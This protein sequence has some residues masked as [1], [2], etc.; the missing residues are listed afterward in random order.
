MRSLAPIFGCCT[1]GVTGQDLRLGH[2]P[3]IV[4]F[5]TR[6]RFGITGMLLAIRS[7][8]DSRVLTFLIIEVPPRCSYDP[9]AALITAG[10]NVSTA[11]HAKWRTGKIERTGRRSRFIIRSC[12][13]GQTINSAHCLAPALCERRLVPL[14][15]AN[16]A[17]ITISGQESP[18]KLVRIDHAGSQADWAA[19]GGAQPRFPLTKRAPGLRWRRVSI[20][21]C[22]P[23]RVGA[24]SARSG[25]ILS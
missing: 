4:A 23:K 13:V 18:K 11:S 7:S 10:F 8:A 6:S 5:F 25:V 19:D 1:L 12:C 17:V 14:Q 2:S 21:P 24:K 15:L 9:E 20:L 3:P 22:S 16:A